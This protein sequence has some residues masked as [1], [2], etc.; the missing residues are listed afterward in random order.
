LSSQLETFLKEQQAEG[1]L[2]SQ[3]KFTLDRG[4]ALEKLAAFQ[5]PRETSWI[6][7]VVQAAVRCGAP[8]LE[9][10]QTST[11]TEVRFCAPETWTLA[12]LEADL[13]DPETSADPALDHLKRGLWSVGINGLRPF[14]CSLPGS[15]QA[16]VWNGNSF[17]QTACQISP[18][19]QL[20]V[21][22]RT[23]FEGKG[24]PLLR[25]IEAATCNAEI[26]KEL[27]SSAFTCPIPLTLDSCRL[28]ALQLCP[29]HGFGASSYP[30][31]LGLTSGDLP[32]FTCLPARSVAMNCR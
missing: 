24:L 27:R 10:R 20:T 4:K 31:F 17:H 5:L 32:S 6:L 25:S 14:H 2:D 28:D 29:E 26:A 9:I 11:D 18:D 19:F 3:G 30:I 7:K 21:S 1:I 13:V 23:I 12:A 22:H 15:A 8:G 16:L